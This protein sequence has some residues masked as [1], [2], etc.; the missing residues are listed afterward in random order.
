ML[1]ENGAVLEHVAIRTEI[2]Q[3]KQLEEQLRS[4]ALTDGLTQLP[5]R[6][7]MLEKLHGAVLR[8]RRLHDYH[9]AV[10]FLD[11]DRFKLVND[12]LGHDVGDE[13]LRQIAQRLRARAARGRHAVAG[14]RATRTPRRAS[15]ATSSWC[16]ST[17]SAA[18]RMP[19]SWRGACCWC[20]RSPTRSALHEVHSSASIGIVAS[21]T[22][23]GDADAL[24]RNADTAMYEAK[25]AG[26]GRYVLFDATMHERVAR[27]LDIEDDLRRALQTDEFYVVYQPIVD[28]R[29]RP[30]ARRRGA[31]ALAPPR[32]RPGAAV[33]FIPIAEETGLIGAIGACVLSEP[34]TSSCAGAPRSAR[35]R[36]PRGVNLSRAQLSQS[37]L[38]EMVPHELLRTG[39]QPQWLQLEVT[40]SVVM[41]DRPLAV[42]HR[43]K[44]LGVRLAMDDFGTGYSSLACLREIPF[45]VIKI[46]RSFVSQ[47][48]A[49]Q[50]PPRT[51]P[52]HRRWW[53]APRH[54][55]RGRRRR[56]PRAGA[57]AA[58]NWAARWPRAICSAGR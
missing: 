31:G 22:N 18:S 23:R 29:Q 8:A 44:G 14:E 50:P 27:T 48:G 13:L 39:M 32:A 58:T 4:A 12:S 35:R 49:E 5:N 56:D 3:R 43:L 2:T 57:S 21:D 36:R 25:R 19:S 54:P 52:G 37:D 41:Q 38:I 26:R 9:F 46:D 1:D 51:D 42:L 6:V 45:D 55:D 28:L 15:A 10:L 24:L 20:C 16:C 40:E 17:A 34:A 33:E 53:R 7:S 47:L 30:A 11:F